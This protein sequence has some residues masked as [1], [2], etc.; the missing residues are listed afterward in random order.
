[1]TV[2]IDHGL[3]NAF[4]EKGSDLHNLLKKKSPTHGTVGR[5]SWEGSNHEGSKIYLKIQRACLAQ[6]EMFPLGLERRGRVRTAVPHSM[7]LK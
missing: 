5:L 7:V 3:Q 4:T 1:M 6:S 2:C